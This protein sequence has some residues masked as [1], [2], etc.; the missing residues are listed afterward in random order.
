MRSAMAEQGRGCPWAPVPPAEVIPV[1]NTA[2]RPVASPW[3][4]RLHL[5][6][7]GVVLGKAIVGVATLF[8]SS[9]GRCV[10]GSA[11]DVSRGI[12]V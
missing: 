11:R 8:N 6:W 1:S 3:L 9:G 10:A 4:W 2:R 5:G 7:V 12:K